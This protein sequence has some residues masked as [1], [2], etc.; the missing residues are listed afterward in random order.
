MDIT[1]EFENRDALLEY[2]KV[3][4][5][6][7]GFYTSIKKSVKTKV[8]IKCHLG[9]NYRCVKPPL[10]RKSSTRLINCP[11]SVVAREFKKLGVWKILEVMD[12][13]NHDPPLNVAGYS[14]ARKL[15]EAEESRVFEL[16]RSGV[17]AAQVLNVLRSEFK[18]KFTVAEDIYNYTRTLRRYNLNGRS[19]ILALCETLR[20]ENFEYNV[21]MNVDGSVERLFFSHKNSLQL[22]RR[23]ANVFVMDCTYRTNKFGMPLLNIVGV[24]ATYSTFNGG[25]VF[26]RE[27]KEPDY[28]WALQQFREYS[29]VTPGVI[30]TDRDLALMNAVSDVF[31]ESVHLLCIWHINKNIAAKWKT[32]FKGDWEQFMEDWNGIVF[33][34]SEFNF[35][36]KWLKLNKNY[37]SDEKTLDYI[38]EYWIPH[39]E[40]FVS[41]F[42]AKYFHIGTV[43]SSRVEGNHSI[44]KQYLGT[45]RLDLFSG[46]IPFIP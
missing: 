41:A 6:A 15:S 17:K 22:C 43:T 13:H 14:R 16:L 11:F 30:A 34:K 45:S 18:N 2:V 38:S 5:E 29:K 42:T 27:E 44:I 3:Y 21:D 9:G 8:W 12:E 19:P 46:E 24:T 28:R 1:K 20:D 10:I 32:I 26:M 39:K 36:E 35:W 37:Q 7:K 23:W 31:P 4:A 25:F 33:E 40:K